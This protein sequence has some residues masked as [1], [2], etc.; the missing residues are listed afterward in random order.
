MGAIRQ[1]PLHNRHIQLPHLAVAAVRDVRSAR[2]DHLVGHLYKECSH[3]LGGV[4]VARVAIDHSNGVDQTWDAVKHGDLEEI[5]GR[6]ERV[7]S[8]GDS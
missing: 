7:Y 6:E 2:S 1:S 3:A 5:E 8:N 4:V